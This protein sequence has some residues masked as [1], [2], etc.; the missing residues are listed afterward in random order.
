MARSLIAS[1][2]L[3][4]GAIIVVDTASKWIQRGYSVLDSVIIDQIVV[5][6][7]FSQDRDEHLIDSGHSVKYF[8]DSTAVDQRGVFKFGRSRSVHK[9]GHSK[10][11]SRVTTR[12]FITLL[13]LSNRR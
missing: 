8:L 7:S 3:G 13:K 11:N 9:I 12:W 5:S 2:C 10:W 6:I 1:P 4:F